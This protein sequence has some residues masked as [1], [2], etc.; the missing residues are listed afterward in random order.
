MT[1]DAELKLNGPLGLADPILR[2]TF[3]RIG[4][5]AAAGLIRVLEGERLPEQPR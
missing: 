4:D 5:R 3:G 1:Y 2:L